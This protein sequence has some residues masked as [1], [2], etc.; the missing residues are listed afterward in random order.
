LV[1]GAVSLVHLSGIQR[2]SK[3]Q[4]ISTLL[5]V[6]LILLF[7]IAGLCFGERQPVS[8]APS[9][10]D[11]DYMSGAP[12]AVGLV[13]VLYSYSGWNAPTYIAGEVRDPQRTL[14]RSIIGALLVVMGIYLSLNAVFLLTTPMDM[15]AGK[16]DVGL[17]AGR[18]I[19]GEFG[20]RIV[21]FLICLGLVSAISSM[22]WIGPRVS[23]VMG[24]D[25][26]ILRFL[27]RKTRNGVPASA[28]LLQLAVAT[29]LLITNSF[30]GV[31]DFIQFSLTFCSFL[32]VLGVIVLR[33]TQPTLLRPYRTWAYPLPPLIFLSV[34]LLVMY[35]LLVERPVQSLAGLA[36]MLAGLLVY[37]ASTTASRRWSKE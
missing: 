10:H 22:T 11:L 6:V 4:N 13:F 15:L 35:Y 31:L 3:L 25:L 2:G 14:P 1:T 27:S 36:T 9:L 5:K 26:P 23:M 28:L 17:I 19:F 12:F 34:T 37:A 21:G 16:L 32:T 20:G 7:I 8:F 30:E 33:R 24:E 29:L 18:Q